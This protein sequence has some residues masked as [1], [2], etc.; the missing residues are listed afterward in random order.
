[1]T[2]DRYTNDWEV[3]F[4]IS[5]AEDIEDVGIKGIVSKVREVVG[6]NPVYSEFLPFFVKRQLSRFPWRG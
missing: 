2:W 6:E 1:M 4:H 3:G 5:H